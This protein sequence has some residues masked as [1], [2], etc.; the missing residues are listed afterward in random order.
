MTIYN[1]NMGIGWASSGVEYAQKYRAELL[2]KSEI[3]FKNIFLD[4]ISLENIQTLTENMG[5]KDEEVIWLYQYFT[6]IKIAPTTYTIEQFQKSLK[7]PIKKIEKTDKNFILRLD[8]EQNYIKCFMK[9]KDELYLDR[10]EY[11]VNGK[12][13]KK[14]VFTY[15]K[16]YSE[17]YSPENNK[18]KRYMREFY[19]EDGTVAY[20]EYMEDQNIYKFDSKVLYSKNEF[21]IYFLEQLNLT[22]ND[23][24]LIDRSTKIAA[25]ILKATSNTNVGVVIHAEHY[26]EG[27]TNDNHILWNNHYD[28][29]LSHSYLLDFIVVSTDTQNNIL[30]QQLKKYYNAKPKI[31]TIPVGS[32]KDL[33]ENMKT[34]FTAMTASRLAQEKHIDWLISAVVKAKMEIPELQFDI[35]GEGGERNKLTA[36]IKKYNAHGYIKLKGHKKLN[37]IY[38]NYSLFLSASTSEGFGLTLMEAVG[39]GLGMIGFD[40]NYG[41]PTFIVDNKNGYKIPF[42][43]SDQDFE[44]VSNALSDAII[45]FYKNKNNID[46]H[47]N[48]L[49]IARNYLENETIIKW[50]QLIDEVLHD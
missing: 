22:K 12:I 24:F 41:N 17:Y 46:F 6:D 9:E 27:L 42:N 28:Y 36:L 18:A 40:V 33:K 8:G 1:L 3:P 34:P 5:Y 14:D 2:R 16:L 4:F 7:N 35:Y 43:I 13:I 44:K 38:K 48:S 47:Q 11:V 50:N 10:A 19:N 23:I 31:Y 49:G 15:T 25:D 37:N 45:K 21:I 26:N 32:L 39:S 29:L 30:K 20:T